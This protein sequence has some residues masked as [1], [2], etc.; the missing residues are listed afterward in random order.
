M[1]NKSRY[2]QCVCSLCWW[3]GLEDCGLQCQG[4]AGF[5]PLIPPPSPPPL[6]SRGGPRAIGGI[7]CTVT[8]ICGVRYQ[9]MLVVSIQT[10]VGCYKSSH[11][12]VHIGVFWV[13][14]NS[15]LQASLWSE[16]TC[17]FKFPSLPPFGSTLGLVGSWVYFWPRIGV[18]GLNHIKVISMSY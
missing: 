15:H 17:N 7:S 5:S 16:Q 11:W 6:S 3:G 1:C 10:V 14:G 9:S 12:L 2:P 13:C 18:W 8:L 4:I